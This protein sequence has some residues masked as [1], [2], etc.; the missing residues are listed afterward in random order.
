MASSANM[1]SAGQISASSRDFRAV[2]D[3][4]FGQKSM[5]TSYK[6]QWDHSQNGSEIWEFICLLI[7]S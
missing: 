1:T 5:Q 2:C 4:V 7:L 6:K 3:S